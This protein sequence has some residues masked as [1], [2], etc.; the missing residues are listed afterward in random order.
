MSILKCCYGFVNNNING[1]RVKQKY[2]PRTN[3]VKLTVML[4]LK[5]Q[6]RPKFIDD[7][8]T[9][10]FNFGQPMSYQQPLGDHI[11]H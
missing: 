7:A 4:K 5:E 1:S 2:C 10:G 6:I 8:N 11:I 9:D 3:A